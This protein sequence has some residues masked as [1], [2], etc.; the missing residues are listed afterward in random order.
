MGSFLDA[1]AAQK[2]KNAEKATRPYA[3]IIV[4]KAGLAEFLESGAEANIL[5]F[6]CGTGVV[7]QEIYDT[8]PRE[9]WGQLKVLG[10]DI[11]QPMLEYLRARGEN[12]GWTGLET[13]IVDGNVSLLY[14]SRSI[15]F[16]LTNSSRRT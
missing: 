11:S 3:K 10:T 2:Y 8:I 12:Q 7:V 5:D 16:K 14:R 15:C 1:E 4:E 13:K 6:A 9:K